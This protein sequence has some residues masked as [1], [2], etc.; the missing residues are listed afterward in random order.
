[1]YINSIIIHSRTIWL[2]LDIQLR[3]NIVEYIHDVEY[4]H[5]FMSYLNFAGKSI[6]RKNEEKGKVF[7]KDENGKENGK[8]EIKKIY[9][10]VGKKG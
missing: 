10:K 7:D 5:E 9:E 3:A 1:M 6:K 8:E 4:I 2:E